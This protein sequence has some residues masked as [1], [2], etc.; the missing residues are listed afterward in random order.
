MLPVTH[1]DKFT[2]LQVLLYTILMV[3]VTILPYLIGMSGLFYL[4]GALVLGA[5]FLL[6]AIKM[7]DEKKKDQPMKTF[8]FSINYLMALFAVLLVDHY[9]LG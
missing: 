4:V 3:I 6:S 9:V 7:M 5:G 1:G 2:R 8:V